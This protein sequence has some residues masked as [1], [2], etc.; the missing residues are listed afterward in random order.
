MTVT[1]TKTLHDRPT[2]PASEGVVPTAVV[3]T[4][5]AAYETRIDYAARVC[6]TV[7][8]DTALAAINDAISQINGPG[9]ETKHEA[10]DR[11]VAAVRKMKIEEDLRADLLHYFNRWRP[12]ADQVE[13]DRVQR[14]ANAAA[15]AEYRAA[16]ER[17]LAERRRQ[18]EAEH[19]AGLKA[20][21]EAER[22]R[23]GLPEKRDR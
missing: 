3:G 14:L 23:R 12:R 11:A 2:W 22:K 6:M 21:A 4:R 18:R 17:E 8:D 10:L 15:A 13:A 9:K 16:H 5:L 19:I 20:M 1:V 7:G